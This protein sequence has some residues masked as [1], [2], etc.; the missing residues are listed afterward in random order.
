MWNF[1]NLAFLYQDSFDCFCSRLPNCI[2]GHEFTVNVC[3]RRMESCVHVVTMQSQRLARQVN[4]QIGGQ[5]GKDIRWQRQQAGVERDR[6]TGQQMDRQA[7]RQTHS[8]SCS[9]QETDW[10]LKATGRQVGRETDTY[11]TGKRTVS[12]VASHP[13]SGLSV[14]IERNVLMQLEWCVVLWRLLSY[15]EHYNVLRIPLAERQREREREHIPTST[16]TATLMCSPPYFTCDTF[17]GCCTFP[18][19]TAQERP[20]W[21][22]TSLVPLI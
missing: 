5:L 1:Q 4:S 13:V 9:K 3:L 11:Q 8:Y 17:V 16:L 7:G 22:N 21:R 19:Q 14:I 20:N 15:G 2:V 6:Q 18:S 12:Q 10:L